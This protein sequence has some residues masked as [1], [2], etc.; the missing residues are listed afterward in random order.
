MNW[1]LVNK[2]QEPMHLDS[3]SSRLLTRNQYWCRCL[4]ILLCIIIVMFVFN[5]SLKIKTQMSALS[6]KSNY[7][8]VFIKQ[9]E[10]NIMKKLD[11][12]KKLN[13]LKLKQ[14][15]TNLIQR[16]RVIQ[17]DAAKKNTTVSLDGLKSRDDLP[18]LL[19]KLSFTTMIEIGVKEGLYAELV[20]SKW[21]KFEHYWGID[22]WEPQ[23]N[24][25]DIANVEIDQQNKFYNQTFAKLVSKF[26]ENRITLIR[27]YS[28]E[29]VVSFSAQSIDFIYL[30]ARHDY[31][32]LTEDLYNY[33]PVLRCGGLFAGHDFRFDGGGPDQD[34]GLCANG[35]RIE[36]AVKKAVL[37][38]ASQA[39]IKK[40]Y[41]TGEPTW[42]SW[43]FLKDC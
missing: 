35:T 26:G 28:T 36:G 15:E 25:K 1:I 29:A 2:N 40:V 38:F 13:D 18:E 32:G 39:S 34:W 11:E 5:E 31:C 37:D 17:R 43:F 19:N 23:K 6:Q 27:N 8:A 30:D 16:L 21:L 4:A 12:G 3:S 7:Q 41:S 33:Y 14:L 9:I 22:P 24:Y 20:L 10:E 42:P